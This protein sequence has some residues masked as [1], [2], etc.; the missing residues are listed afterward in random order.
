M[1]TMRK[2][3]A[4]ALAVGSVLALAGCNLGTNVANYDAYPTSL[5]DVVDL[6]GDDDLDVLTLGSGAGVF[7]NDGDGSL[8]GEAVEDL[9]W[10]AVEGHALGDVD[11][12][13]DLD[14]VDLGGGTVSLV[15]GAGEGGF[16]PAEPIVTIGT[17]TTVGLGDLDGDD[18]LD[19]VT[20][21]YTYGLEVRAGDGAGGF[22]APTAFDIGSAEFFSAGNLE[23]V[24]LDG[25]GALDV[26]MTGL[27][28]DHQGNQA[29][30]DVLL[31]DGEGG[32]GAYTLYPGP[33]GATNSPGLSLGDVDE[34]GDLDAVTGNTF[35]EAFS[36]LAGDGEGGF[37]AAVDVPTKG[38]PIDTA[39]GD[40]DDDGHLD[41]VSVQLGR[42]AAEVHF[43]DGEGGFADAHDIDSGGQAAYRVMTG[44]L[45]GDGR[46]DVVTG[47][48]G[49]EGSGSVVGVA[50]NRLR[51]RQH[52]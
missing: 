6:D 11:G 32:L 25:D 7:L 10:P 38:E 47:T 34:D 36:V 40:I 52:G 15:L 13:G 8:D 5:A 37:A 43:G 14:R 21:S 23:V 19:L 3:G 48:S 26:V 12:D 1:G 17:L 30:V 16:G 27:G 35:V 46:D 24:D 18:D 22:G 20:T 31:G 33:E 50:L 28:F 44:D 4:A 2:V 29:F 49:R 45:D 41:V 9:T 42:G 39:L 51:S